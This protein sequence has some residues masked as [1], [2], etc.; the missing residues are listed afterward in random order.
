MRVFGVS[1]ATLLIVF[2]AFVI[3]AKWGGGF[4]SKIPVVGGL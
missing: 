2:V 4:V 3:G 1:L